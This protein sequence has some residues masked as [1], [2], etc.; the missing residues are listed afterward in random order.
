M[1]RFPPSSIALSQS[2]IDFHFREIQIKE[3][4]YAQGFTRKE[5]HRYYRERYGSFDGFDSEDDEAISAQTPSSELASRTRPDQA[6]QT[7]RLRGEKR[8]PSGR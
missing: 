4:L 2:D 3:Q 8:M 5:V 6:S 1:I 7:V